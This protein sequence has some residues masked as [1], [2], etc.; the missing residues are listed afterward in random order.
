[1]EK[2]G[3]KKEACMRKNIFFHAR[4]DGAPL[5]IDSFEY[6]ILVEDLD[7]SD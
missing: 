1:M 4:A 5:W 2:I 3:M 7:S 6:A